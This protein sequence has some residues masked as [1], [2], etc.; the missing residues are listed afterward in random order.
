MAGNGAANNPPL[1]NA[2]FPRAARQNPAGLWLQGAPGGA[3]RAPQMLWT[4]QPDPAQALVLESIQVLLQESQ[5]IAYF[6]V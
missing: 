4:R 3:Q 5:G 6:L 2:D 1:L